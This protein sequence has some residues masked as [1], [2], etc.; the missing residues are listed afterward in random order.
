MKR[1]ANTRTVVLLLCC[2][3]FSMCSFGCQA[4]YQSEGAK[5]QATQ[6]SFASTVRVLAMLNRSG[7]FTQEEQEDISVLIDQ[8]NLYLKEWEACY[9]SGKTR[10]DLVP[11]INALLNEL[12]ERIFMSEA[13]VVVEANNVTQ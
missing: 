6:T 12:E 13:P 11:L 2:C 9:I 3:I 10:P 5:L 4:L 8:G 7:Q 1:A